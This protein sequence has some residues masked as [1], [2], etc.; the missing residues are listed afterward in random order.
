MAFFGNRIVDQTLWSGSLPGMDKCMFFRI[1]DQSIIFDGK[2]FGENF[3]CSTILFEDH[4]LCIVGLV[5]D[6]KYIFN[7]HGVVFGKIIDDT[8]EYL[9]DE[10][11]RLL[12]VENITQFVTSSLSIEDIQIFKLIDAFY[13]RRVDQ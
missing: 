8:F 9:N 6:I 2:V 11:K 12:Q 3:L 7:R 4:T 5:Q 13:V 1:G 10:D